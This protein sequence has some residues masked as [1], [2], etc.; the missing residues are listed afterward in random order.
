MYGLNPEN[1][2]SKNLIIKRLQSGTIL[3]PY[4]WYFVTKM[5]FQLVPG[6]RNIQEK[7]EK[8]CYLEENISKER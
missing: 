2:F 5:L 7:L 4:K 3:F 8:V 1:L 6:F